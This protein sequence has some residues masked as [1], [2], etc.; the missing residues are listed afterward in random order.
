VQITLSGIGTVQAFNTVA[1]KSHT[2]GEI[3]RVLF[4]KDQD[5][6]PGDG[7]AVIDPLP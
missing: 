3:E 7:L 5:A 2:D 6:K 4:Q 1:V